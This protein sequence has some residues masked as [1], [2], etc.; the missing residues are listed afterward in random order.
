MREDPDALNDGI[1][2][3]CEVVA[4]CG[5]D[6]CVVVA[7]SAQVIDACSPS[8]ILTSSAQSLRTPSNREF[9]RVIVDCFK[10]F[11]EAPP[12]SSVGIYMASPK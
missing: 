3:E 7:R 4:Q 5:V 12:S 1:E 9:V 6:R 2:G 8:T 11:D 10:R